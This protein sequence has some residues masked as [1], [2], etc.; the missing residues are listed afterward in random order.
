MKKILVFYII[1]IFAVFAL[2]VFAVS[3]ALGDNFKEG[4]GKTG[5]PAGYPTSAIDPNPGNFLVRM[6]GRVLSPIG[7]GVTAMLIL[8]YGGYTL[9]SARG[10]EQKVEKAKAIIINTIIGLIVLFSA[11]ALVKLVLPLW[12]HVTQ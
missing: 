11:Y 10:D 12:L 5:E 3:A 7:L 8:S 6:L 1:L 2:E 9:M 4:L